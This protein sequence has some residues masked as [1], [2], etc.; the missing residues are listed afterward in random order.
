MAGL[1]SVALPVL[2]LCVPYININMACL[3]ASTGNHNASLVI[4]KLRFKLSI[5]PRACGCA[6]CAFV[7]VA[8][9]QLLRT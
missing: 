3:H 2:S 8:L 9:L 5:L 1:K 6:Q 7:A 4:A